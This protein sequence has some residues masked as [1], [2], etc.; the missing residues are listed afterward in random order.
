M[1]CEDANRTG[2]R[3]GYNSQQSISQEVLNVEKSSDHGV[4]KSDDAYQDEEP[5]YFGEENLS[6]IGDMSHLCE[7]C[8]VST[9]RN[10]FF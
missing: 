9:R 6:N 4:S 1:N 2:T 8:L 5:I 3:T 10:Y 7:D